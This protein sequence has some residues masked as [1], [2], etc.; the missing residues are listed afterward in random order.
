MNLHFCSSVYEQ[1]FRLASSSVGVMLIPAVCSPWASHCQAVLSSGY[2]WLC[3]RDLVRELSFS[4]RQD[5]LADSFLLPCPIS[6]ILLQGRQQCTMQR[7]NANSAVISG[8]WSR[9]P[10]S[11]G[12]CSHSTHLFPAKPSPAGCCGTTQAPDRE[13]KSAICVQISWGWLPLTASLGWQAHVLTSVWSHRYLQCWKPEAGPRAKNQ[14]AFHEVLSTSHISI[15]PHF[16]SYQLPASRPP[17]TFIWK[18]SAYQK[19]ELYR[20]STPNLA[21]PNTV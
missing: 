9:C 7:R 18:C 13:F 14:R 3:M 17:Q 11:P 1:C 6:H 21:V 16:L 5:A 8:P 12:Q 20:R 4:N 2:R 10:G 19:P 15:K